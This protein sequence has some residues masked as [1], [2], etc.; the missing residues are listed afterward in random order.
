[1]RLA[2]DHAQAPPNRFRNDSDIFERGN[3][4]SKRAALVAAEN[5]AANA[6]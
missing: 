3:P 5:G 4:I 2:E 1:M 6:R